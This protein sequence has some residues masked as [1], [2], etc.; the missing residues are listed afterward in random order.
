MKANVAWSTDE[1]EKIAGKTS[2]KKAVLDLV[3]TK[4]AFIYSSTKYNQSELL[5]GVKEEM[6]TAPIIGCTSNGGI[7]TQEGY[8]TSEKGF[9]GILALGDNE[10]AV[11][12][13]G[14]PKL[15]D[16]R[17]TGQRAAKL[18]MQKVGTSN[19]PSYFYMIANSGDEMEYAKG[20]QDI[21]GDVPCFGG[22]VGIDEPKKEK[23]FTDDCIFEKGVAV[24]FFYTNKDIKNILDSKY[25]ETINSGVITKVTEKKQIDEIGNIQ[26]LKQYCEWI[27]AKNKE[28]DGEK[29][30][31][32]SILKPLGIK[33][34]NGEDII[35]Y[36]PTKANKD[37]SIE[38][39]NNISVN[40][41]IIQM[42]ISKQELIDSPKLILRELNNRIKEN[43]KEVAGY[44]IIQNQYRRSEVINNID[45]MIK[46]L[47]NEIGD[48]PFIMP[49]TNGEY[50]R[51]DHTANLFG[52][53][54]I[55]ATAICK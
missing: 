5:S 48:V 37:Y 33:N 16:A 4:V 24:A 14:I 29:I 19:S 55:S 22:T 41:A 15:L 40:T 12:T 11:G 42:Q 34:E 21:I 23:I 10:T 36:Q 39:K 52:T 20:I 2:A 28:V 44:I 31:E 47:K 26:A 13:A 46:K 43:E 49:F 1:N 8:I 32:K 35:I 3:Q 30:L 27:K 6:G 38:L 51:G 7:A 25:H 45:E 50:G 17:Q 9:V 54:M 53:L 18:A